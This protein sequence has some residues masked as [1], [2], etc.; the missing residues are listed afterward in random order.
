ML[1]LV[2]WCAFQQLPALIRERIALVLMFRG[3][4]QSIGTPWVRQ[5]LNL[6]EFLCP[7]VENGEHK[8]DERKRGYG[9]I[10]I[11]EKE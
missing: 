7:A 3:R 9:I 11:A 2:K 10:G 6:G 1:E 8:T 5:P 4:F